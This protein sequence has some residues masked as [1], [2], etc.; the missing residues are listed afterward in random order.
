M[1][2]LGKATPR[3]ILS[4][5]L[6]YVNKNRTL[7]N[8]DITAHSW[9]IIQN[10]PYFSPLL[11]EN[12]V[13][14]LGSFSA[15]HPSKRKEYVDNYMQNGDG[16]TSAPSGTPYI[17]WK[18]LGGQDLSG[19]P[20][21]TQGV[22]KDL[23]IN[24][25]YDKYTLIQPDEYPTSAES[26]LGP[27]WVDDVRDREPPPDDLSTIKK[28]S[29]WLGVTDTLVTSSVASTSTSTSTSISTTTLPKLVYVNQRAVK[30]GLWWGIESTDFLNKNMPFWVTIKRGGTPSSA[31]HETAIVVSLGIGSSSQAFDLYLSNNKRPRLV[32]Y[33]RGR[34]A[35]DDFQTLA[36]EAEALDTTISSATA[37]A[38]SNEQ[39]FEYD[40][41]KLMDSDKDIEIGFMTIGGRLVIS[42]NN[43]IMVY[44]RIQKDAGQDTGRI[45][46]CQI[47]PGALRIYGTNIQAVINVSPMVFAPLSI[48]ALPV[49]TIPP[50]LDPDTGNTNPAPPYRNILNNGDIGENSVS[51]LPTDPD[52][53]TVLFGIDSRSFSGDGGSDLPSGVGFHKEGDVNFISASNLGITSLSSSDFY[54]LVMKADNTTVTFSGTT[55]VMPNGGTPYFFRLKGGSKSVPSQYNLLM[56]DV[57]EDVINITETKQAPDY[58]HVKGNANVTLYNKGGKYDFLKGRQYGVRIYWGWNDVYDL[59]FTG[60]TLNATSVEQAGRETIDVSCE[61]YM[62]ILNN[63]HII[64]SPFYDGMVMFYAAK[65]MLNRAGIDAVIND[66]DN[67]SDYFLPSGFAFT[68]PAVRFE[69][70][71]MIFECLT[72]IV[73]RAEAF[74]YFDNFGRAHVKRLPGGLFSVGS[75]ENISRVFTR[76]PGGPNTILDE[77]NVTYDLSST[78][79]RISIFTVD[80]DTRNA[81]FYT[82]SAVGSEDLLQYRR[83]FLEDQAALGEYEVAV[84]RAEE[85]SERLFFPIRKTSFKTIGSTSV[86]DPSVSSG[87][88]NPLDFIE[89]DGE[90]FRLLSVARKYSADSNDFT[91]EYNAEWL[92][93][94]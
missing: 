4:D 66:W 18:A 46:E 68:K 1:L 16:T 80:R 53:N 70:K 40:F 87:I 62:F 82:K 29:D 55:F 75:G 74:F 8:F 23:I 22:I 63:R 20:I 19:V 61:D 65:D 50:T 78:V 3:V 36:N 89:V 56:L 52:S 6:P 11:A 33:Y 42:V 32:D 41:S 44:T 43:N 57:T 25:E 48:L 21:D 38:P 37:P 5:F 35:Y 28:W 64:N 83:I 81:V 10:S 58:F 76:N 77:K 91:N 54:V 84:A 45:A 30:D 88:A 12:V 94:A 26:Y 93:S 60:M 72:Y 24:G 14:P 59:S 2:N 67:A 73:K 69:S 49:P 90:E 34:V 31:D 86:E 27:E 71:Q 7:H 92:G 79:N 15:I 9:K 13:D 47:N 17:L 85:L 39:E 51:R